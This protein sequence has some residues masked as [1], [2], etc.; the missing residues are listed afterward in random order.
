MFA[1]TASIQPF[2]SFLGGMQNEIVIV[3]ICIAYVTFCYLKKQNYISTCNLNNNSC[4][5][6]LRTK[7]ATSMFLKEFYY[8]NFDTIQQFDCHDPDIKIYQNDCR[9][10]LE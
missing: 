9:F 10:F 4:K 7:I 3:R 8:S 6:P 2:R 5:L 1:Y